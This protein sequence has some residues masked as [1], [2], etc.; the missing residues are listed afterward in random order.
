MYCIDL[1]GQWFKR[2]V[3]IKYVYTDKYR[4]SNWLVKCDCGKEFIT[5]GIYLRRA[6]NP[7][8]MCNSC[9]KS[10]ERNSQFG[11]DVSGKNNSNY[12]HGFSGTK[13]YENSFSSSR[14]MAVS[15]H[16]KNLTDNERSKL[17]MLYEI[18]EFLGPEFQ[19]DHIVPISKGGLHHPDNMRVI[20]AKEN[21]IKRAKLDY[22]LQSPQICFKFPKEAV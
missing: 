20:L 21:N 16:L 17:L 19:V 22:Q 12:R 5:V 18:S 7:I 8:T 15:T 1:K 13:S 4:R 14:R 3:V 6:H 11:K 9:S 10:G 2:L